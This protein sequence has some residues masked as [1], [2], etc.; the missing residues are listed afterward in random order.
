MLWT[1]M[2]AWLVPIGL[3]LVLER[4]GDFAALDRV[5]EPLFCRLLSFVIRIDVATHGLTAGAL[6]S[7]LQT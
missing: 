7:R 3:G 5:M 4:K 6:R 1:T 2:L